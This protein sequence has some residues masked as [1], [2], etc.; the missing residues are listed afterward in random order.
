MDVEKRIEELKIVPVVVLQSAA[1]AVP[2]A[3]A[4]TAAGLPLAE[5]TFRT[6]AAEESIR[7]IAGAFPE[8]LVGAGTVSSVEQA[9]KAVEAVDTSVGRVVEAVKEMGGSVL[10]TADH[11]NA[12]KRVDEDGELKKGI[13]IFPGVCTPTELMMLLKYDLRVAKFFPAE[14]YGGLKTIRALSG[15][16]PQMRF[17]PTG[18]INAGNVKEYLADPRIIACGGSWMVKDSL[19]K[20]GN[21]DEIRRLTAEAVNLVK[22]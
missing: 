14:Q 8:M 6:E 18:G 2:L 7:R 11:G 10:L 16:F 1:D 5:V 12:H 22:G 21:F 20:A 17:M 4:L 13:P 9:V 19:I 15:P 3:D